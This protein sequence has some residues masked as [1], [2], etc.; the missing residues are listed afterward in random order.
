M[1]YRAPQH[2]EAGAEGGDRT[3]RETCSGVLQT[4][5]PPWLF[6]GMVCGADAGIRTRITTALNRRRMPGSATSAWVEGATGLEPA[7]SWMRTRCL[8]NLAMLP[9]GG[10]AGNSTRSS[11]LQGRNATRQH[12]GPMIGEACG[13]RTRGMCIDSAPRTA[14]LL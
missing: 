10:S 11:C 1:G 12:F 2:P 13:I 6:L 8:T 9:F 7:I 4:P 3:H 5:S 14:R